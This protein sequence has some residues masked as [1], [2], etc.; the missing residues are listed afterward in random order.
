M[1]KLFVEQPLALPGLLIIRARI[2]EITE[3]RRGTRRVLPGVPL[4]IVLS[5]EL[6]NVECRPREYKL[7]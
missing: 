7:P 6:S 2:S 5:A 1:R 4:T 3:I